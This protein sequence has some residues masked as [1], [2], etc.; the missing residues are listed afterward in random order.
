MSTYYFDDIQFAIPI[1]GCTDVLADNYDSNATINDNNCYYTIPGCTDNNAYNF[2]VSANT[3]DDSGLYYDFSR[4][5]ILR[6]LQ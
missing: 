2:D 1:L 6:R 3:S 4:Y 5:I